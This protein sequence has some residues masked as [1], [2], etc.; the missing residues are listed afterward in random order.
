MA[1]MGAMIEHSYATANLDL[2]AKALQKIGSEKC[3]MVTDAGRP[4]HPSPFESMKIFVEEMLD[5]GLT[6]KDI[7]IMTK[8][9]LLNSL[10][11]HNCAL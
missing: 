9:T 2:V 11:L 1:D 7:E 10:I 5:R 6:K 8:K 3:V 4:H